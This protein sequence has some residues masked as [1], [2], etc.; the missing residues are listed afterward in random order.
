[1]HLASDQ[2]SVS[3]GA[4]SSTHRIRI[5]ARTSGGPGG[6]PQFL[7]YS[8]GVLIENLTINNSPV[9]ESP[10]GGNN[11][12]RNNTRISSSLSLCPG[13]DGGGN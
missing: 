9:S 8:D 11:T 7:G 10:C 13:T 5:T 3:R 2:G 12:V 1:M 6:G 4:S